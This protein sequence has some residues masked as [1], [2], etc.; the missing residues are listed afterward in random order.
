MSPERTR[1]PRVMPLVLIAMALVALVA[2]C[3]DDGEDS[4]R[5][6]PAPG[7]GNAAF[8]DLPRYPRSDPFG[9]LS[10][11]EG[12]LARTYRTTGATPDAVLEF[13]ADALPERGWT[14]VEPVNREDTRRRADYVNGSN[15]LELSARAVDDR[16]EPDSNGAIVQYSLVVRPT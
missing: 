5:E 3:G 7:T 14:P 12:V 4:A 10:E 13:Y 1:R 8:D 16:T 11:S 2:G 15:R 9:P 6:A